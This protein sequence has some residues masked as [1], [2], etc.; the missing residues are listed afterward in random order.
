MFL[1]IFAGV[2]FALDNIQHLAFMEKVQ[3]NAEIFSCEPCGFTCGKLS[4]WSRHIAT[5]KHLGAQSDVS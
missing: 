4:E 1:R 5:R 3:K 2:F